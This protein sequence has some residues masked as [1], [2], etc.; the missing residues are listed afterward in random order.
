MGLVATMLALLL[1]LLVNSAKTSYDTTRN[2][3]IQMPSKVALLDQMLAIYGP[4]A[5]EVRGAAWSRKR[6]GACGPAL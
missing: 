4:E 2:A 6:S 5:A 1:G 3:V